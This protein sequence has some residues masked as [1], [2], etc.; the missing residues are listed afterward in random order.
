MKS[1]AKTAARFLEALLVFSAG[2]CRAWERRAIV[3][4]VMTNSEAGAYWETPDSR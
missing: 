1:S 3:E 2:M 4:A